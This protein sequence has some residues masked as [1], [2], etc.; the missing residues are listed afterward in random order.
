[1]TLFSK[2]T[3]GNYT[4]PPKMNMEDEI[5]IIQNKLNT[6]LEDLKTTKKLQ[7]DTLIML[8]KLHKK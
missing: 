5:V 2:K 8:E 4:S 1:M 3:Y 7:S 6:I